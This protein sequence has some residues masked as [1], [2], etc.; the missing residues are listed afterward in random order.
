[1]FTRLL[2]TIPDQAWNLL[3][4][5]FLG[6]YDW[7]KDH[8]IT[9]LVFYWRELWHLIGGLVIGLAIGYLLLG[10]IPKILVRSIPVALVFS[11]I[12]YKEFFIEVPL[13]KDGWDFKNVVD[14][15]T[16]TSGTTL[17]VSIL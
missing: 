11:I 10:H 12:F 6:P 13:Q 5:K 16:W 1:M 15:I 17:G 9:S 2:T 7:T 8:D 14:V 3:L 4:S